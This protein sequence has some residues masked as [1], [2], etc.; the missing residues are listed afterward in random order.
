[1]SDTSATAGAVVKAIDGVMPMSVALAGFP[2]AV[3]IIAVLVLLVRAGLVG[4]ALKLSGY[5]IAALGLVGT[6]TFILQPLFG[7]ANLASLLFAA[8]LT[9]LALVLLRRG[10]VG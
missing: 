6:G 10:R 1:M 2:R 5:A 3:L 4:R 9:A 8:W 7:L